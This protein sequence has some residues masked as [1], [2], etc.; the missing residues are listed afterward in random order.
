[1]EKLEALAVIVA[2]LI[3]SIVG[4]LEI[5]DRLSGHGHKRKDRK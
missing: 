5:R 2:S 4:V 1:M 3:A